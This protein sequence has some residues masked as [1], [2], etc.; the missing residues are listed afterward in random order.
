MLMLFSLQSKY[1]L[2]K[3]KNENNM[4]NISMAVDRFFRS[5]RYLKILFHPFFQEKIVCDE[6]NCSFATCIFEEIL[7]HNVV[8]QT[9]K[10]IKK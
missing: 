7:Q 5:Y 9:V 6:I 2:S 1:I 3:K 10:S 8:F 4:S